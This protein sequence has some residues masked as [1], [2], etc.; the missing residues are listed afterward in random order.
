MEQAKSIAAEL[1]AKAQQIQSHDF[2]DF[3]CAQRFQDIVELAQ[4]AVEAMGAYDVTESK[5][6]DS[7]RE[8][9]DS[10]AKEV[11]SES[12]K[13]SETAGVD[14]KLSEGKGAQSGQR[15]SGKA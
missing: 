7:K 12:A 10:K 1:S 6:L 11:K 3:E 13:S 9:S 4:Q 15:T 5:T 14:I 2:H 8:K